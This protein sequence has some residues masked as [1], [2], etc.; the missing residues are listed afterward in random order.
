MAERHGIPEEV[1]LQCPLLLVKCLFFLLDVLFNELFPV[2]VE[3]LEDKSLLV[4]VGWLPGRIVTL[5]LSNQ[6][7][8]LLLTLCVIMIIASTSCGKQVGEETHRFG[9]RRVAHRLSIVLV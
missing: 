3:M 6:A 5:R 7:F 9:P 2:I 4:R 8:E 1:L